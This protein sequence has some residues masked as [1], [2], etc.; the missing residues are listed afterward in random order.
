MKRM[1]ITG[2]LTPIGTLVVLKSNVKEIEGCLLKG[3]EKGEISG[4][5]APYH[6][7]NIEG[8]E[9]CFSKSYFKKQ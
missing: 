7:I 3:G 2:K 1:N 4:Y 9:Y 8:K 5:S 6:I